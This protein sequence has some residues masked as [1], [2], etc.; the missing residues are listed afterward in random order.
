[1]LTAATLWLLDPSGPTVTLDLP[2]PPEAGAGWLSPLA[3]LLML[4]S[5]VLIV[6][7]RRRLLAK[8]ASGL[9]T[10]ALG[11]ALSNAVLDLGS[12]LMPNRP[13]AEWIMKLEEALAVD[14]ISEHVGWPDR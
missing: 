5:V 12:T 9:R 2:P 13:V 14:D 7:Q 4:A 10:L 3:F 6:R 8:G 1:M 11:A